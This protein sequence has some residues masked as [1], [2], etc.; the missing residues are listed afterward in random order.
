MSKTLDSACFPALRESSVRLLG[1]V[2]LIALLCAPAALH[3]Q[4]IR[5]WEDQFLDRSKL[6]SLEN[7]LIDTVQG[8]ITLS[9][10]LESSTQGQNFRAV[11]SGID[12]TFFEPTEIRNLTLNPP[13]LV[14]DID[15]IPGE[16]N[17]YLVTEFQ[18]RQIFTYNA[19]TG[20]AVGTDLGSGKN[21]NSPQDAFP[22]IENGNTLKVLITDS[23]E[24]KVIKVNAGNGNLEWIFSS[25]LLSPNDAIVLPRAPEV[26]ICDTGNNRI[27]AVDTTTD[28]INFEIGRGEFF[29]PVDVDFDPT[30]PENVDVYLVTDELNHR[31]VLVRRDTG[32]ITTI[33][34]QKGVSGNTDST[35]TQPIDADALPNGNILIADAGNNRLIEVNRQGQIVW[36]F[37]KEVFDIRDADRINAGPHLNKTI[38]AM[39]ENAS[40]NNLT[41]KRLVYQ[42][43][44]FLSEPEAFGGPVDFDSLRFTANIPSETSIGLQLRTVQ[45]L[46]DTSN[47]QWFGPTSSDDFYTISPAAINPNRHDGDRFYQFRAYL[48]TQNPLKTP[49]L[50]SV[51]VK[52][53]SFSVDSSGRARSVVIQDSANAVITAWRRLEFDTNQGPPGTGSIDVD[54]MTATG[55]TVLTKI[56]A[57]N[58]TT[59]P[60]DIG[61]DNELALRGR[62]ALRLRANLQTNSAAVSPRLLRWKIDWNSVRL[63]PSQTTFVNAG[64]AN[65]DFYRVNSVA[66]DS[67][68]VQVVDPNVLPLRDSLSVEVR[69]SLVGDTERTT[70]FIDRAS[71]SFFRSRPGL[72]LVVATQATSNN[73]QL[74][75]RD[76]DT[77]TVSYADPLDPSDRSSAMAMIIQRT[78]PTIQ[79]ESFSAVKLDTVEVGQTVFV[80]VQG[81]TDQNLSPTSPDTIL[82]RIFDSGT[83]DNENLVLIEVGTNSGTFRNASGIVLEDEPTPAGDGR[84]FVTSGSRVIAS[85]QDPNLDEPVVL[86]EAFVA[87]PGGPT[88]LTE[89]FLLQIAPNPYRAASRLPLKMRVQVQ[90]GEM[91]VRQ[92]EIFNIAGEKV[93]T[94]PDG[95][96]RFN[97][98]TTIRSSQG[99]TIVLDW[100]NL[101]GD[102]NELVATGTYFAK[103]HLTLTDLQGTTNQ[104]TDLQKLVVVQQ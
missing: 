36:R 82:A 10:K 43:E 48:Q 9:P 32:E 94:I 20:L 71:R 56:F 67:A 55:D 74:E 72:R 91:T 75:V 18:S 89:K 16:P 3:A 26:L 21:I 51:E 83:S 59:T 22:F 63:G 80:R 2:F 42:S 58:S 68:Y 101:L 57:L 52:A 65:V 77:L 31:V 23:Q 39:R 62:Q 15:E 45:N 25:G 13:I 64:G 49:E 1:R 40:A 98:S 12:D 44:Y 102:D 46:G 104:V 27:I 50:M 14:A 29:N 97:G 76:R 35:L 17:V 66:G 7:A 8:F 24:R 81:E 95:Q 70:L 61:P 99:A 96:I 88:T 19:E 6:Q 34:G 90:A 5:S 100:W 30:S 28:A 54:I 93:R 86:A 85:Y 53:T 60:V 79:I 78:L 73:R 4:T 38:V 47:A 87:G 92:V 69:S 103:I 37:A 33:F 84:L 11:L 41:A